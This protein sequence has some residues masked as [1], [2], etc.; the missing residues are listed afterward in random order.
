MRSI[1]FGLQILAVAALVMGVVLGISSLGSVY[2]RDAGVPIIAGS[3][4]AAVVL[5][6]L[7]AILVALDDIT[8]N[9]QRAANALDRIAK[10][11]TGVA[12]DLPPDAA[13][14]LREVQRRNT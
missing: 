6:V 9:V 14:R 3:I 2:T 1:G 8:R 5:Y 7:G 13:K 10:A 4:G 11:Q 12:S